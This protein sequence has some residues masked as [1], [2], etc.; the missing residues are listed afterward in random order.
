[1]MSIIDVKEQDTTIDTIMAGH[2]T[3]IPEKADMRTILG[4]LAE[5]VR[6]VIVNQVLV[7][8]VTL[9]STQRGL[10]L[11]KH[12]LRHRNMHTET[13][14]FCRGTIG[15]LHRTS[16]LRVEE[17]TLMTNTMDPHRLLFFLLL[18]LLIP[19][20]DPM[21]RYIRHGITRTV[22]PEIFHAVS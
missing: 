10:F 15:Y 22:A 4:H 9:S 1:M 5:T 19:R 17:D 20:M 7:A 6:I 14:I 11:K 12:G 3:S 8:A 16:Y 18:L 2:T 13:L 21:L